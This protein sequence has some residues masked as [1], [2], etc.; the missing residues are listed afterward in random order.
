[1]EDAVDEGEAFM[2]A[3]SLTPEQLDTIMFR[4]QVAMGI[5]RIYDVLLAVLAATKPERAAEL[6]ERHSEGMLWYPP[7]DIEFVP[8]DAELNKEDG[9]GT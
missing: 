1:M 6:L 5:A 2:E 4:A 3:E 9:E 8:A 7:F